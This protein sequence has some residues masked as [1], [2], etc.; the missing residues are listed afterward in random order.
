M[1][2]FLK[3]VFITGFVS[4]LY[5]SGT[6]LVS[7]SAQSTTDA[8]NSGYSVL[9]LLLEDEQ[10]LTVIRRAKMVI[11]LSEIGD[12]STRLVDEISDNSKQL[13]DQLELLAEEKPVIIFTDFSDDTITSATLNSLRMTTAKEFLFDSDNFEKNLL[14]SQL[15]ILP[16]LIHLAEELEGKETN[17]NRKHWL[18]DLASRYKKH[19]QQINSRI[20]IS[21]K[22]SS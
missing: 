2:A 10:H 18:N 14:I 16:L 19:Y 13:L 6:M 5:I 4:A 1:P 12:T 9:R 22:E 17:A 20:S 15:K 3:L 7:A 8:M 11:T 21:T